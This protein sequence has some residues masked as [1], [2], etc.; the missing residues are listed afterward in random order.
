MKSL[1]SELRK[2]CVHVT[3]E[4]PPIPELCVCQLP[5][6]PSFK[7]GKWR[8]QEAKPFSFSFKLTNLKETK[9]LKAVLSCSLDRKDTDLPKKTAPL[10]QSR[11]NGN[12][13]SNLAAR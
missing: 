2:H 13:R 8:L 7:I 12:L 10:R 11:S 4:T 1:P 5:S 6:A 3:A 9:L